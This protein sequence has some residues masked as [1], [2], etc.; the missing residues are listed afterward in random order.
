MT[1]RALAGLGWK[2]W[3]GNGVA[4]TLDIARL[5]LS[6]PREWLDRTF[7]SDAVKATLA[8]WGMHLDFAPDIAGGAVFPYLEVDGQPELRHGDRPGR[9]R[10]DG[11]RAGRHG[12]GEGRRHRD[13]LARRR[14]AD[15][16]RKGGRRAPRFGRDPQRDEGGDRRRRAGRAARQAAA[17]GL[18]RSGFRCRD[19]ELPPRAGHDDDPPGPRR[20]ARL[21]GRPGASPLRLCA[22]RAVARGH[23]AH[24][25][26]G[27]RGPAAGCAGPGGRPA[28]RGRPVSRAG[29]QACP[30]GAGAHAARQDPR[31]CRRRDRRRPTGKT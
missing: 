17:E 14:G 1:G 3:R 22:S 10:R 30:M 2:T 21:A 8:A 13:R 5:L 29:G 11:P 28:D 19:D 15:R 16:R 26:A 7:E 27:R 20:P 6:S 18:R 9:R 4:G 12:Q 23:G 31:R 24:L 25:P